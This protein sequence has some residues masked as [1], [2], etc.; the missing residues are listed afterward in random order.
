MKV[1][2]IIAVADQ[3]NSGGYF[4]RNEHLDVYVAIEGFSQ[5]VMN[6]VFDVVV[7]N[8]SSYCDCCGRRWCGLDYNGHEK[9]DFRFKINKED[10]NCIFY[11]IDG[12][13]SYCY[14]EDF[15]K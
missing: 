11:H 14:L 7:Q 2:P 1:K 8:Y 13:K 10:A 15:Y 4:I 5:I 9:S 3:N 6:R 12:T